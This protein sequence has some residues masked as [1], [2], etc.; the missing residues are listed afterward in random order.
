MDLSA[1]DLERFKAGESIAGAVAV[2]VAKVEAHEDD[3]Q[4]FVDGGDLITHIRM[5][6]D[7]L[8]ADVFTAAASAWTCHDIAVFDPI[9]VWRKRSLNRIEVASDFQSLG[10]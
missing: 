8:G 4:F 5:G 10:I 1:V 2:G 6:N 7:A 3:S 9:S